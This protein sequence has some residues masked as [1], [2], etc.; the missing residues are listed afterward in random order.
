VLSQFRSGNFPIDGFI[1]DFE[2]YTPTPD[3]QLPVTGSPTFADFT[4]N[5]AVWPAPLDQLKEYHSKWQVRFGGI[6]KPR[7]GN[8]DLLIMAKSKGWLLPN[9]RDLNYS[10]ADVRTWYAQQTQHFLTDGV[11]FYWNDGNTLFYDTT[12][13]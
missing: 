3:Y 2:W 5:S 12:L 8:S 13:P 4:Y 1:S 9:A 7:L 10:I 11:D 6:R